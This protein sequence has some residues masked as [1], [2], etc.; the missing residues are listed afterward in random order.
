MS[1]QD[2]LREL[3]NDN[4]PVDKKKVIIRLV[5]FLIFAALGVTFIT[6]GVSNIGRR[7]EG[8]QEITAAPDA[9]VAYY[10]LGVSFQYYLSG[11]SGEIRLAARELEDLYGASLKDAW[12]LLDPVNTYEG[13]DNL[14]TLNRSLGREVAVS[15]ELYEV[16]ADALER[17]DRGE[18]YSLFAGA[19]MA[20]WETL[21]FALDP[22]EFD[23]ANDPEEAERLARLA[24]A[25]A[26]R[27]NFSLELLDAESCRV[28]FTVDQGYLDLLEELELTESPILDLN[29]LRE[30]WRL[31][32]T[33]NRLE[34]RG[35]H[36]GYLLSEDGIFLALSEY[37][38]GGDFCLYGLKGEAETAAALRPLRAGTCAV[39]LRAFGL[40]GEPGYYAVE[41]AGETLLRHPWLPADGSFRELLLAAFVVGE[42]LTAPDTCYACLRFW[43]CDTEAELFALAKSSPLSVALLLR[44]DPAAVWTDAADVSPVTENGF[45]VKPIP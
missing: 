26:E 36:R 39:Q 40:G 16:L 44:E 9:E 24:A 25:T 34:A 17:T 6:L 20:E 23:P 19:L 33:A 45:T 21:R 13:F 22:T 42:G 1:R 2:D 35:Y 18:G 8:L 30:A 31:Q 10:Q 4:K 12:R 37:A 7:D 28:R 14:A 3:I 5:A 29:V 15:P 41:G 27:S 11:S 32:L 38:D 43:A